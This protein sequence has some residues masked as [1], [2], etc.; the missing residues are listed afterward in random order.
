MSEPHRRIQRD[1]ESNPD[2]LR[3][4]D[5]VADDAICVDVRSTRLNRA[6][7]T[8]AVRRAVGLLRSA[9]FSRSPFRGHVPADTVVGIP[10]VVSPAL[11][12]AIATAESVRTAWP[13]GLDSADPDG[14]LA[15]DGLHGWAVQ[16]AGELLT[17]LGIID[18]CLV[19]GHRAAAYGKPDLHRAWRIAVQQAGTGDLL[20]VLALTD[21][22]VATAGPPRGAPLRELHSP[23][24]HSRGIT[25]SAQDLS[26]VTVIADSMA[27]ADVLAATVCVLGVDAVR[28]ASSTFDCAILAVDRFGDLHTAGP[29]PTTSAGLRT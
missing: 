6:D 7:T 9:E 11:C 21:A 4:V 19:V 8:A 12:D 22:A 1:P 14:H 16:C 5:R 20:A 17:G 28:W 24:G 25:G 13:G 23:G 2:G 10:P 18:F 3:Y 26:S 15:S 29:I 27:I